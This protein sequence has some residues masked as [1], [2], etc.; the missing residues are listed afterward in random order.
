MFEIEMDTLFLIVN[1]RRISLTEVDQCR[2]CHFTAYV[3]LFVFCSLK[4]IVSFTA[5]PGHRS[6][7]IAF[8]LALFYSFA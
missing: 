6:V 4:W 8:L 3:N 5:Y 7:M 2:L 1:D